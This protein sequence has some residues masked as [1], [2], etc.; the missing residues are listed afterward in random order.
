MSL[1]LCLP[2]SIYIGAASLGHAGVLQG[3]AEGMA[4]DAGLPHATRPTQIQQAATLVRHV[5]KRGTDI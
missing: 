1:F 5:P 4:G 2:V 3:L